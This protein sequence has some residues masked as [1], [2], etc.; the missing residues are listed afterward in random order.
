MRSFSDMSQL[1]KGN[2]LVYAKT[3]TAGCFSKVNAT[4][5]AWQKQRHAICYHYGGGNPCYCYFGIQFEDK[6]HQR[7]RC[8]KS[9]GV[10]RKSAKE[11]KADFIADGYQQGGGG[12]QRKVTV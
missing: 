5:R 8:K 2:S 10:D 9:H 11:S 1:F 12:V 6:V 4:Y 7:Q 3:V